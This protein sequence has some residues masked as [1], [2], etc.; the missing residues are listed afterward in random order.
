MLICKKLK[1]IMK[2]I[3]IIVFHIVLTDF[4]Y[5]QENLSSN[6]DSLVKC[7]DSLS[8]I[9]SYSKALKDYESAYSVKQTDE[10]KRKI[11]YTKYLILAQE[12]FNQLVKAA[13]SLF[14]NKDYVGA[15]EL[16]IRSITIKPKVYSIHHRINEIDIILKKEEENN[17]NSNSK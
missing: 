6:Y 15:K 12:E 13:D 9:E 11:G 17:H 1:L 3:F 8:N 14:N 4:C 10:L 16:Y 7:A 5:C 2:I